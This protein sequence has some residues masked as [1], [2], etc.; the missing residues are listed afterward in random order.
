MKHPD[1]IC[2]ELDGKVALF[3]SS[4][5]DYLELN[6]TGSAIWKALTTQSTLSEPC[7]GLQKDYN[8]SPDDYLADVQS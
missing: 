7:A 3:Q 5:Y 6:D 8:V 1:V 4:T 2:T